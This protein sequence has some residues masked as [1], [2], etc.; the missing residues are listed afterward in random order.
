MEGADIDGDEE[1]DYKKHV[2]MIANTLLQINE[3]T[4]KVSTNITKMNLLSFS[5]NSSL[6]QRAHKTE[7]LQLIKS[8]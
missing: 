5:R 2:Q 1:F 8:A 3:P 4:I 7:H 6:C